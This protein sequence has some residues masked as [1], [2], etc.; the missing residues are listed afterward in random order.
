VCGGWR[1]LR[2]DPGAQRRLQLQHRRP[3]EPLS[4]QWADTAL[5]AASLLADQR[6]HHAQD[7]QQQPARLRCGRARRRTSHR[8]AADRGRRDGRRHVWATGPRAGL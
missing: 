2:R 7:Q 4:A 5:A 3:A 6:A 8:R 1:R